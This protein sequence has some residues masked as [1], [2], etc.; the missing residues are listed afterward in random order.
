MR[1]GLTTV[2]WLGWKQF[3][4]CEIEGAAEALKA[5]KQ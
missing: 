3:L 5:A 1:N 4:N 2:K